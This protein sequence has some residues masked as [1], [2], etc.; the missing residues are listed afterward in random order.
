MIPALSVLATCAEILF[1]LFLIAGRQMRLSAALSGILPMT[2][3]L[4]GWISAVLERQA[5]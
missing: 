5:G 1:G 3:G 4:L 2:F